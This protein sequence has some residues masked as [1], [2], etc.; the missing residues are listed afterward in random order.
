MSA[1]ILDRPIYHAL[2]GPQREFGHGDARAVRYHNDVE[3]FASTVDGSSASYDALAD[4][5]DREE[6]LM[7]VQR[8]GDC[9]SSG[10]TLVDSKLGVQM[11]ADQVALSS[12]PDDILQLGIADNDEMVALAAL[13]KPG[14][15]LD[16][17]Q[18]LGKFWGIKED[19]QLIAMAGERMKLGDYCEVS[20][21]CTHPN[22]RGRG[23][24]EIL[25]RWVASEIIRRKQRPFLHCYADN[26]QAIRLYQK[27]GFRIR[28]EMQ[29][30]TICR[31]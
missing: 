23:F 27:L 8:E 30:L 22:A 24:G 11:V 29:V 4:L 17:T 10:L 28:T 14:P 7:L 20:G 3:P 6:Q 13:T 31:E 5:L 15:F 26:E 25:S 16:R 19:D 21:V 12:R 2:R 9:I 18:K 1:H